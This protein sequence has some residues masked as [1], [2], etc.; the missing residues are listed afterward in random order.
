MKKYKKLII[1]GIFLIVLT[2][3]TQYLDGNQ[4]IIPDKIITLDQ[5]WSHAWKIEKS[6]FG[7]IFV[8]PLAQALNF[9]EIYIGAFGSIALVSILIKL[10]TIRSS[11]KSTVQ[12]QKM[13]LI[14]PD[15]ARIEAKYKGRDDQQ[16]KMQ[17]AT[18][19]Q[20]LYKKHDINPFG[21]MG[22]L[23]LSFPIMIAM[24]QAVGRA[25]NVIQGTFLGETLS[26]TPKMG[27]AEGN[28]VYIG[29]FVFMGI[30]QFASMWVPQ[31]LAKRK[32]KLRP[33]DK[34]PETPGQSMMYVSLI[35]IVAL[36]FSWPIGMSLYWMVTS[37]VTITQTLLIDWKYT[38][39]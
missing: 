20:A 21:A 35:M 38:D 17:K 3:C 11:I 32:V 27:F 6:W 28:Y 23:L 36:G 19:L 26:G 9:F 7:A 2:G 24:Y 14:G 22:G 31:Y 5:S 37:L 34:K 30:A 39:K 18:E 8:W 25:G 4:Q 13:Q 16:A 29:I 12:Q 1:L 33:G 10:V 15:Q